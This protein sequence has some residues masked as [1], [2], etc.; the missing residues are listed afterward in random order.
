MIVT[1][2]IVTATIKL[3]I[4]IQQTLI[5]ALLVKHIPFISSPIV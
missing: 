3:N 5:L 2:I 4:T 1:V